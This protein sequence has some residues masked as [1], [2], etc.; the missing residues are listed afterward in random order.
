[1][2]KVQFSLYSI[3]FC[4]YLLV[5]L[6]G[7]P[8]FSGLLRFPSM[9]KRETR[10]SIRTTRKIQMGLPQLSLHASISSQ[11]FKESEVGQC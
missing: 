5:F 9:A 6:C 11:G 2:N 4:C 7:V 10:S 3:W 8:K 1:M